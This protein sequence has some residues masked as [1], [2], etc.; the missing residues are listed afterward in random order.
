MEPTTQA[1]AKFAHLLPRGCR[2]WLDAYDMLSAELGKHDDEAKIQY[3]VKDCSQESPE[4]LLGLTKVT[5]GFLLARVA[6]ELLPL[7]L[8]RAAVYSMVDNSYRQ[9]SPTTELLDFLHKMADAA[10]RRS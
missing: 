7:R 10:P 4:A 6:E 3:V 1:P 2:T 5:K 9:L 8:T